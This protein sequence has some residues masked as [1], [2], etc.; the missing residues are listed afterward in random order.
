MLL[1]GISVGG[2]STRERKCV[3]PCNVCFKVFKSVL[4]PNKLKLWQQGRHVFACK[5]CG[6]KFKTITKSF[7]VAS[8]TTIRA[9]ETSPCG[10]RTTIDEVILKS[11]HHSAD[12]K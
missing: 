3:H 4:T 7:C 8:L 5:G 9:F 2:Q 12:L 1:D 11:H 6:K 10:A